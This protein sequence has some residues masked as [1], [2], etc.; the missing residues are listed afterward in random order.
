[1]TGSAQDRWR[2]ASGQTLSEEVLAR[3]M[4]GRPLDELGLEKVEGRID[5]RGLPAPVPRRLARYE[6]AGWFIE[7]LGNLVRFEEV[8]LRGLDLS[9]ASLD[10]FRFHRCIIENCLFD[11]ARCHDWRMWESRT[12]ETSFRKADLR[13]AT[14]GPWS[15]GKGNT[16]SR[17]DFARA[18]FRDCTSMTAIF[19]DCDFSRARLDKVQFQRC[20]IVRCTFAG[21]LDEVEFDGRV[22]EPDMREPNRYEDIDMSDALLRLAEFWGIDLPAFRLPHD[23]GLRVIR[24]YPCVVTAAVKALQGRDDKAGRVLRA[25]LSDERTVKRGYPFG[26]SNRADWVLLGGEELAELADATLSK[27][28]DACRG[29]DLTTLELFGI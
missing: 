15:A 25:V 10:S 26:L 4:A 5:L 29:A 23:P 12:R 27:A 6:Q 13:R 2:T 18:D 24:N 3:L 21:I 8:A 17:V 11:G 9:G 19:E 1:M 16:F 28:E 22:F 14:L 20:G 7:K